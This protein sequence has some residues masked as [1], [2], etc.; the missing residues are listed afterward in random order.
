MLA[1]RLYLEED[2]TIGSLNLYARQPDAFDDSAV[3]LGEIV[4]TH[5]AIAA[6][7]IQGRNAAEQ[8]S[9]AL[10]SN[11]EIGVAMGV[12]ITRHHVTQ[13]E[14]FDLLRMASRHSHRTVREIASEVARTGTVEFPATATS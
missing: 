12:L 11:R 5:A 6:S 1:F 10:D 4:A 14:A 8:L 13:Q 3:L 9:A 7:G 2:T